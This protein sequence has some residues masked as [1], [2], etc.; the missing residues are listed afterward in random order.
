MMVYASM[1]TTADICTL[2]GPVVRVLGYYDVFNYPLKSAEI[3]QFLSV[4]GVTPYE[5]EGAL[6]EMVADGKIVK[7]RGHFFLP[8]NDD[9]IVD[10]RLMMEAH[11]DRMWGAARRMASLMRH[12]PFVRGVFVSGQLCRY[13][14]DDKSDVDYFI[15]TEPGRLWIVRTLFV[16]FRRT[17]LFNSRKYFCTNYYVTSENLEIR[18]RNPYVACEVAS[19]KPIYNLPLYERFMHRNA[20]VRSFYPNF[21]M[22]RIE[23]RSMAGGGT[24]LR[25]TL[26]RLFPAPM[27][28][29]LDRGL[30]NLTRRFWRRKFPGMDP[31]AFE[32]ALM[33]RRDES[34]AH[35][36]DMSPRVLNQYRERLEQYGVADD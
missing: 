34:R 13:I 18:E 10:R 26:E 36:N 24:R 11:G 27:A 4:D 1:I 2:Y 20:W 30:M 16:M 3:H 32:A 8:H 28:E 21:A 35:P 17:L 29:R 6:A 25:D 22:D 12:A 23:I 19:L 5:L 15:V 14:A 31:E 7:D 9:A 33:T